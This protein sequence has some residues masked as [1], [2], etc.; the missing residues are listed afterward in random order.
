[1]QNELGTPGEPSGRSATQGIAILVVDDDPI[2]RSI[3]RDQLGAR[4]FQVD[5]CGSARDAL[6][7]I[8]HRRYDLMIVDIFLPHRDGRS[9]HTSVQTA[10]PALARR[11]I[12]MSHWEP[13]GAI[14]EY[15]GANGLFIKKPFSADDLIDG[16]RLATTSVPS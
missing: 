5:T 6:N 8:R 11:T 12:F 14:A 3:V 15:I 10:N 4:G 2:A 13:A 9:L 1:M 16:I 7:L